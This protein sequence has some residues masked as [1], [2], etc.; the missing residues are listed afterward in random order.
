MV[1]SSHGAWRRHLA[2]R[3]L[4]LYHVTFS[5]RCL[6]WLAP[7][8]TRRIIFNKAGDGRM[9][10][11]LGRHHNNSPAGPLLWTFGARHRSRTNRLHAHLKQILLGAARV[12]CI[13]ISGPSSDRGTA[14]S[15]KCNG[16][17]SLFRIT[18][19]LTIHAYFDAHR[20]TQGTGRRTRLHQSSRRALQEFPLAFSVSRR[21]RNP[22]FSFRLLS[23][24]QRIRTACF[25]ATFF[26]LYPQE[27]PIC[28]I[29]DLLGGPYVADP[30][31]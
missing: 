1:P 21:L 22:L 13:S 25:R 26:A 23:R 27:I 4:S 24:C 6:Q 20:T 11:Q 31:S 17:G 10:T 2:P 28:S 12:G 8:W 7:I 9:H 14:S 3:P 16:Q 29:E 15:L 30:K 18:L 19:R 5:Q